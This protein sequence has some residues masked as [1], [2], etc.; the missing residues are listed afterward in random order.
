MIVFAAQ[1]H[2]APSLKQAHYAP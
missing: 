2:A 1:R